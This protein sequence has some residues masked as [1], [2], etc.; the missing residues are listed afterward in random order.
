LN[1]LDALLRILPAVRSNTVA[2]A[3]SIRRQLMVTIQLKIIPQSMASDEVPRL[4]HMRNDEEGEELDND[5]IDD[6]IA[7]ESS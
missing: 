1:G 2:A 7:C 4:S 5:D 3:V 6:F